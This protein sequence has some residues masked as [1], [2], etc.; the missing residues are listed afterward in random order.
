MI[1]TK[2]QLKEYLEADQLYAY[3]PKS[4]LKR[5]LYRLHGNE[6]CHAFRYVE[7]L[8]KMEYHL[9]TGHK[10]RY[11][12]YH[13]KL[14]RLGL[15]YGIRINPNVTG[16]GLNIIHLAG[17]GGCIVNCKK[18]GNYLRLQSGV[19]IGVVDN[20]DNAPSIGDFVSF[21]L[22]SK[23][24]GKIEIGDYVKVLPNA[25]VTK[26][27]PGGSIVGGVPAR[28]IRKL[29]DEEINTISNTLVNN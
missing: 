23:A 9:N 17:G 24:F 10:L 19:V 5:V 22:G 6:Q 1:K 28:V 8:R 7:C 16:K 15:R 18:A 26:D 3:V 2:A 20:A 29:T 25:V 11:S 27:I 21:G 12:Y 4:K 13:F 14:S